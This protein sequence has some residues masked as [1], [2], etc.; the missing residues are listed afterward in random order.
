MSLCKPVNTPACLT[1]I[2]SESDGESVEQCHCQELIGSLF[3]RA[4]RTRPDISAA[5]NLHCRY[6]SNPKEI[7]LVAAKRV[8]RYLRGTVDV[9]LWFPRQSK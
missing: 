5:V 4:T 9:A 7:H 8:L 1:G 3:F 6:S 2:A